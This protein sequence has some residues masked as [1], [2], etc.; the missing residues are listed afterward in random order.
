MSARR[1]LIA[2]AALGLEEA[3]AGELRALLPADE[4]ATV[5]PRAG[6]GAVAWEGSVESALGATIWLRAASRVLVPIHTCAAPTPEALYDGARAVPWG[7]HLPRGATF[8]VEVTQSA[9]GPLPHT[10]FAALKVKDAVVDRLRDERGGERPDVDTAHPGLRLHVHVE[11]AEATLAVDLAGPLHRRGYRDAGRGR[12]SPRDRAPGHEA[13][14]RETLAAGALLLAEWPARADAGAPLLDPMCGSGTLLI[15]AALI[16]ARIAPGTLRATTRPPTEWTAVDGRSWARL[17]DDARAAARPLPVDLIGFDADPRAVALARAGLERALGARAAGRAIVE[18]RALAELAPPAGAPRGVVVTN[19]PWGERL[20]D[21]TELGPL[22]EELGDLL[23]R[24]FPGWTAFVLAGNPALA[25]RLGLRP[26][27]RHALFSGPIECRL[28]EVPIA[29]TPPVGDAGPA[30]RR[31]SPASEAFANRLAKNLRHLRKW[32]RRE[33]TNA[34]RVYDADLPEYAVAIDLYADAAQIQEYAPPSTIEAA[35]AERRLR[36]VM[37]RAPEAL[38]LPPES[39]FLK[40]RRRQ[41]PETQYGRMD[42]RGVERVVDEGRAKLIVNLTD[43]LDTGLYLDERPVRARLAELAQGKALLNLFCYTGTATVQAALGGARSSVSVDLSNTYLAWAERNFALNRLDRRAHRLER[44]DVPQW[45][46]AARPRSFD[47]AFVAPPTFSNSKSAD[48][49]DVQRDHAALLAAVA[50]LLTDG[51]V[52]LFSVHARRFALDEA[53]LG[54][55]YAIED[56]TAR[57]IPEDFR[58]DPRVH[59]CAL[60]RK[61]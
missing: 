6:R 45:I 58:R 31:P 16:A 30:W 36:D 54:G 17:V 25:K 41:R 18:T 10:H 9:G 39:C 40:T 44:G 48:D 61:R 42:E 38:G 2:T 32:A 50:P 51:G 14:L 35:T 20:G 33:Q 1:P 8:A 47:V 37:L 29:E 28:L 56:W 5:A 15:E 53:A 21:P 23:R 13:P 57:T 43:F 49:F 12:R 55:L 11:G 26:T 3:V 24:R 46:R 19:P 34:F 7:D 4:A 60:L 27:R 22:Y 52:V 59:R